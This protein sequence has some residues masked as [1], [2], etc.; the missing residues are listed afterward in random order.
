[1]IEKR[2]TKIQKMEKYIRQNLFQLLITLLLTVLVSI[3]LF[4]WR[5][6]SSVER[7]VANLE[8]CVL[9]I[10]GQMKMND[11]LQEERI[12]NLAQDFENNRIEISKRLDK[13]ETLLLQNLGKARVSGSSKMP[14][15]ALLTGG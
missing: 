14:E 1:M 6:Y 12:K 3:Y 11:S 13:F 7:R 5:Q 15:K 9:K 8:Q 10:E 2:P 4:V